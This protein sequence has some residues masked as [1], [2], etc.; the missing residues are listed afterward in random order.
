MQTPDGIIGYALYI[1]KYCCAYYECNK[2]QI[3][4]VYAV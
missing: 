2:Y 1:V 3:S 4:I